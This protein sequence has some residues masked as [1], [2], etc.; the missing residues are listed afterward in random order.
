MRSEKA[1]PA[2]GECLPFV[3]P[4]AP[5]CSFRRPSPGQVWGE[6]FVSIYLT[7][8]SLS[9]QSRQ[10]TG[11]ATRA[12]VY[13]TRAHVFLLLAGGEAQGHGSK[14]A[15]VETRLGVFFF[16][17]Y[18][19]LQAPSFILEEL[20][21]IFFFLP[22]ILK[23]YFIF[24]NTERKWNLVRGDFFCTGYQW[25][26]GLTRILL[27]IKGHRKDCA[28]HTT[29]LSYAVDFREFISSFKF[30]QQFVKVQVVIE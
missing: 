27:L 6:S 30:F 23:I 16:F 24:G 28:T 10:M 15:K 20:I 26:H 22:C 2:V 11:P 14:S 5:V 3:L 8:D 25:H 19:S 13:H 17:L 21:Y 1:V 9:F 18:Y 4:W 12:W 29:T 7:W